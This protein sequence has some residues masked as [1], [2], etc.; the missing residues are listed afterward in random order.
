MMMNGSSTINNDQTNGF[1]RR[2][3]IFPKDFHDGHGTLARG[4]RTKKTLLSFVFCLV[5][6]KIESLKADGITIHKSL[7]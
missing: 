2:E 3:T 6:I 7:K 5:F 1:W 4:T